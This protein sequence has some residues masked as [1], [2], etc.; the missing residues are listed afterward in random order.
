MSDGLLGPGP[1]SRVRRLPKKASYDAGVI[2]AILDEAPFC[3]V[4]AVVEGRAVT[5][6]T[7]H[8]RDGRT[9]YLHG[10][11]SNALLK[12]IVESGEACV[13]VTL[14]DGLRLARSGFESSI[15]YRSVVV[16]GAATLVGDD[17]QKRR[18]LDLFVDAVLPGRA[19][20]VRAMSDQ[21]CRL[22]MV[23]AVSIDE[24]SAK[25]SA[26]P[27]EDLDDDLE[28]PIWSGTVPA[29]LRYEAPVPSSDGAMASG[30]VP[31]PESVRRL[32]GRQ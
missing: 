31:L 15:A 17:A 5:L 25:V 2:Y 11:Q 32:L 22:T 1:H 21:E 3:H 8:A 19:S 18:V 29:R 20:E 4:A 30:G 13:S 27:T 7:L 16:F 6:P 9:L 23:V 14:Y 26:G 24:A 28:L 10:S 12:A